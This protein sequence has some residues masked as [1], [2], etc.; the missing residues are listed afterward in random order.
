MRK[1][2]SLIALIV[3]TAAQ[4]P[5]IE[6]KAAGHVWAGLGVDSN[7]PRDFASPGSQTFPD[8]FLFALVDGQAALRAGKSISIFGNYTA[9]GRKF[10]FLGSQDTLV[11]SANLEID[12]KMSPSIGVGLLGR[13]RDRRG[14][15]RDYTDLVGGAYV[16]FVPDASVDVRVSVAGHR[17]LFYN[18]FAYSWWGPDANIS[19]RYRFNRQ[20]SL[21]IS[22]QFNPRSYNANRNPKPDEPDV[23]DTVRQDAVLGGSVNY[24]FRGPFQFSLGY[25]YFDQTSNS[26]GESIRRHRISAM[27]GA[28]LPWGIMALASGVLQ[29]AAYPDGIYL[30]QELAVIEDDENSS[31]VT[32]KVVKPLGEHFELDIR[33]AG[34]FN[35]FPGIQFFYTRHVV[36]LGLGINF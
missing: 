2:R 20:H 3:F 7:A 14:A 12:F 16:A 19:A 4:S 6:F 5:A 18:R 35:Q 23:I 8:G 32:L 34:Y 36:S 13:A 28:R 33:Y 9:A 29:F 10:V 21:S 24:S 25:G 11:Q 30:S 27:A 1:T 15:E 17:F 31:S 22:G 26:H